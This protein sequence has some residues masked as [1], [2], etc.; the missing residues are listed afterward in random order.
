[1]RRLLT[2]ALAV[3]LAACANAPRAAPLAAVAPPGSPVAEHGAL[4]VQGGQVVDAHGR[5]VTLRGM[6]LVWSQWEPEA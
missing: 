4:S 6:S 1:V 5:P 3:L 2:L